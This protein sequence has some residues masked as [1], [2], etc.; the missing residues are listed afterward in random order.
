MG[1]ETQMRSTSMF[2]L[3]IV[4]GDNATVGKHDICLKQIVDGEAILAGEVS[5]AVAK[6]QTGDNGR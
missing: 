1:T 2:V 3:G 6:R 5:S 4:G